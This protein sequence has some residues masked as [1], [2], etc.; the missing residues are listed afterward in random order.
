MGSYS[1]RS[2]KSCFFIFPPSL[3]R[4]VHFI[5]K[6]R[7]NCFF[8]Y[9]F[10]YLFSAQGWDWLIH[11][12]ERISLGRRMNLTVGDFLLKLLNIAGQIYEPL[13]QLQS[14]R[15]PPG[16]SETPLF[17]HPHSKQAAQSL[18]CS[19]QFSHC[20]MCKL[21]S[22]PVNVLYGRLFASVYFF[23]RNVKGLTGEKFGVGSVSTT[24]LLTKKGTKNTCLSTICY[25]RKIKKLLFRSCHPHGS[26]SFWT[27]LPLRISMLPDSW[28]VIRCAP[29]LILSLPLM[30]SKTRQSPQV[31]APS[32]FRLMINISLK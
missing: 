5:R 16:V 6:Q 27:T 30:L 29:T 10:I 1:N 15:I 25:Q 32:V 26:A 9:L 28:L 13:L 18:L 31:N 11:L 2:N 8:I 3:I 22:C 4:W 19:G 21:P 24:F 12:T 14:S 17:R 7:K 20:E 23:V